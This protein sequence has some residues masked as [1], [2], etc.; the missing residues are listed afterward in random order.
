MQN[1]LA[2][3]SREDLFPIEGLRVGLYPHQAFAIYWSLQSWHEN[4]NVLLLADEMGVGKTLEYI[5][6]WAVHRNLKYWE[7]FT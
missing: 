3:Q 4:S 5:G 7:G 1:R 2:I 6:L